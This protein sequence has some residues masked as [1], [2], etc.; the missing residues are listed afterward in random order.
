MLFDFIFPNSFSRDTYLYF[1]I[2]ELQ[3]IILPNASPDII[4]PSDLSHKAPTDLECYLYTF[5]A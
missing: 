2:E 3:I 4:P 1:T 5:V